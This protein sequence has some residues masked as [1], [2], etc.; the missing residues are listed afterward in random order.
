MIGKVKDANGNF[1]NI[2]MDLQPMAETQKHPLVENTTNQKNTRIPFTM[3]EDPTNK[4]VQIYE[5]TTYHIAAGN[6][7]I[8]LAK[9]AQQQV[10]YINEHPGLRGIGTIRQRE[11][12]F[13]ILVA[14][15]KT[16]NPHI[17]PTTSLQYE[18]THRANTHQI[19]PNPA[20]TRQN[21][22]DEDDLRT[23][24]IM[25]EHEILF[26]DQNGFMNQTPLAFEDRSDLRNQAP[27]TPNN[28]HGLNA[29]SLLTIKPN[30][31]QRKP[32]QENTTSNTQ[33]NTKT[34]H[35]STQ[36]PENQKKN[37]K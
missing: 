16:D 2:I 33:E 34:H 9:P 12:T 27:L 18:G 29:H 22:S 20:E 5:G 4:R 21:N 30:K 11:H 3:E 10:E 1:H 17:N 7:T 14:E 28:Q 32:L 24:R 26:E 31:Q 19:K 13:R 8:K 25:R 36:K 37:Q 15:I 6:T 35:I 23:E